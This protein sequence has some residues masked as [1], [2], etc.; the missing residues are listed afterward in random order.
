[1]VMLQKFWHHLLPL[2]LFQI[3]SFFCG[4]KVHF[5]RI[6][7]T[8]YSS[9]IH[10]LCEERKSCGFQTTSGLVN[11]DCFYNFVA[12]PFSKQCG[13]SSNEQ[14]SDFGQNSATY[15]EAW[16]CCLQLFRK[17]CVIHAWKCCLCGQLQSMQMNKFSLQT[18]W[19][20]ENVQ[21]DADS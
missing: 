7:K 12:K 3:L 20:W 1:M 6:S 9:K 5:W 13:F 17:E 19:E 10:L 18:A 15:K 11:N 4:K 2:M 14:L 16:F 21:K 8:E